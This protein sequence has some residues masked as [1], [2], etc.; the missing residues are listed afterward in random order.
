M[1]RFRDLGEFKQDVH[2]VVEYLKESPPAAGLSE[3]LYPGEIE[4]R[5]RLARL[6]DGISIDDTTWGELMALCDRFGGST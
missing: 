6:A 1:A 3:V 4:H 5:T 2:E